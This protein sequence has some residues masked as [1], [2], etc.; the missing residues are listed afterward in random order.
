MESSS[1]RFLSSVLGDPGA[2][3]LTKAGERWPVLQ[4]VLVPRAILAWLSIEARHDYEGQLPGIDN[5]YL[6]FM[7]SEHGFTG[8]IAIGDNNYSFTDASL[9]HLAASVGVAMGIDS[10][11]VDPQ[12]RDQDIQRLGKSID[13]LAKAHAATEDILAKKVFEVDGDDLEKSIRICADCGHGAVSKH[14]PGPSFDCEVAGCK[15][16]G[17]TTEK[18][19]APGPASAP[20]SQMSA[21]APAAPQK[22]PKIAKPSKPVTAVKPAPLPKLPKLPK[23]KLAM[24]QTR[25]PCPECGMPQF[26]GEKFNGC[27][28]FAELAKSVS[29]TRDQ[30]GMTLTFGHGWD[31]E[32]LEVFLETVNGRQS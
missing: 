9:L 30:D 2:Q 27:L 15:C 1:Y 14:G 16:R 3:A 22:Q 20:Q 17:L 5:S 4:N 23:I 11:P 8:A 7:K 28:C 18:A 31:P 19:E 13:L 29:A 32:T 24:S 6:S 25:K 12:L 26:S 10:N 21:D